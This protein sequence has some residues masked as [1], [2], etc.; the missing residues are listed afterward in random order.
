[1]N[2]PVALT[3]VLAFLT[4][5]VLAAIL[6]PQL[7]DSVWSWWASPGRFPLQNIIVEG[8]H[9][10]SGDSVLTVASVPTGISL[11]ALDLAPI[12]IRLELHRWIDHVCIYRRLPSTLVIHLKEVE[13]ILLVSGDQMGVIGSNGEYLGP[14]WSGITWD[15]PMLAG[16]TS[17]GPV[18]EVSILG[19]KS[20]DMMAIVN[21]AAEAHAQVP[22]VFRAISDF[23][24]K[25]DRI[26]MNLVDGNSEV[27]VLKSASGTNWKALREFLLGRRNMDFSNQKVL[28]DLKFPEW[29]I[30]SPDSG[31]ATRLIPHEVGAFN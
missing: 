1:L 23:Y 9:W 16:A 5:V 12:E 6:G 13:P 10:L 30:V 20:E 31:K 14:I 21:C 7:Y 3:V 27:S 24:M 17:Q 18:G 2:V 26:C 11:V 15:L 25:D 28:I 4:V 22:D 29:V 19:M 8:N